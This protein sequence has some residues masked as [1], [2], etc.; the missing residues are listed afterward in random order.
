MSV[1]ITP[2]F[3]LIPAAAARQVPYNWGTLT[4]LADATGGTSPD[5]SMARVTIQASRRNML[6]TH[7]NCDELLYLIR[8]RIR[9]LAGT[10]WMSMEPGDTL[11]IARSCPSGAG[12]QRRRRGNAGG[13]FGGRPANRAAGGA[14]RI[15]GTGTEP[16]P[17]CGNL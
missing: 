11:R 12:H 10:Q 2:E 6:H 3:S 15:G 9:H 16:V 8:G 5:V 1:I 7:P 14:F 4:F 13:L 17:R